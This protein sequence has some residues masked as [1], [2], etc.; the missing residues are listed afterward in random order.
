MCPGCGSIP[1]DSAYINQPMNAEISGT[2]NQCFFSLSLLPSLKK[3]K[4]EE[5]V[6][7]YRECKNLRA[8]LSLIRLALRN[9]VEFVQG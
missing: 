5:E 2:P 3:K 1:G 4:D 7:L 9:D 8:E 6:L